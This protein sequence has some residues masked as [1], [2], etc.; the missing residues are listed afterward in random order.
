MTRPLSIWT[1]NLS[2]AEI[3]RIAYLSGNTNLANFAANIEEFEALEDK[4]EDELKAEYDRGFADGEMEG[5]GTDAD[6]MISALR[7]E[8]EALKVQ[9]NQ[10]RDNLQATLNWLNG[11]DCKT[12]KS[13]KAFEKQLRAS[14]LAT[15]RY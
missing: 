9:H 10:C 5:L 13:R 3:E 2:H 15:P 12:I 14:L 11:K 7:E 1:A 8:V 4:R 6:A